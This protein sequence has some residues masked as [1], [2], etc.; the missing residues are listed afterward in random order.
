[1]RNYEFT[2]IFRANDDNVSKGK[3]LVK[4]EFEKAGVAV[5]KEEDHGVRILAYTI[6]KEDKGHY[7]Y[8]ELKAEPETITKLEKDLNLMS[9][10]LKFLFVR[11][12]A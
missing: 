3:E 6:K 9:P 11:K 5:T 7:L 1:M 10:V 12:D 8:F 2:V 4:A